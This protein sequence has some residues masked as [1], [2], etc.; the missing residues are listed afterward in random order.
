MMKWQGDDV[1]SLIR[2]GSNAEFQLVDARP[3]AK[4]SQSLDFVEAAMPL[5]YI[6]AYEASVERMEIKRGEEAA[7][8]VIN[9]AVDLSSR[10]FLLRETPDDPISLFVI[11]PPGTAYRSKGH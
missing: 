5:T 3:V 8:L 2:Y 11:V 9:G 4:K 1:G 10:L 6:T 7:L